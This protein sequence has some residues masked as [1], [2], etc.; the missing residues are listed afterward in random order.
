MNPLHPLV[1]VVDDD[2]SVRES[3]PDLLKA[4]GLRVETFS[5]AEDF[6]VSGSVGN[7]KCLIL[8]VAMPNMTGPELQH[9]LKARGTNVPIVFITGVRDENVRGRL[10]EDGAIDCL[11]KPF[12]HTDL[13]QALMTALDEG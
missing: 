11:F 4:F 3:L 10:I 8:D 1:S 13:R 12:S 9:E 2:E 7:T 6:L 5:S